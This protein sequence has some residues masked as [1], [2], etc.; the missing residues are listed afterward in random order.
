VMRTLITER[1]VTAINS[2]DI[3]KKNGESSVS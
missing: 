2:Q 3:P 1:L